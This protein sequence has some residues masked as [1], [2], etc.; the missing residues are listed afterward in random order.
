MKRAVA[1]LLALV[2]AAAL[3]GALAPAAD[4]ELTTSVYRTDGVDGHWDGATTNAIPAHVWD[5]QVI[6]NTVYVGGQFTE[7]V[8]AHD[9]W[10]RP[11]QPFLAAF[12][13]TSGR[14]IDWWRPQLDAPV[15]A[16]D[17]SADGSLLVAGEFDHVNGE[18]HSNLVAL[19]PRSGAIDHR[20]N[21]QVLRPGTTEQSVIRDLYRHDGQLYVVGN[22]TRIEGGPATT[23]IQVTK[24]ARVDART[25]APD[26]TW[27]PVIAGRSAWAVTTSADGQRVHLGGEFSYVNGATDTAL[28]ATVNASNGA[29]TPGWN[30]GTNMPRASFWPEGGIVYDL[31][32]YGNNLFV[33]GAEHYWEVR[34]SLNGAQLRYNAIS[35]DSQRV[36]VFGDRVYISCHCYKRAPATQIIEVS[37]STGAKL[38]DLGG[39]LV[40][41]DGSWAFAKA[42]DGCLWSGGDFYAT[43]RLVGGNGSR[44][45][46]GRIARMCDSAG[47]FPHDVPSLTPPAPAPDP[48]L[49]IDRG[50]E[51]R[52]LADGT[53]PLGWTHAAFDDS[54]WATGRGELGYGDGDEA[55]VV[56]RN[57]RSVLFRRTFEADPATTPYL[58]LRLNVD[59]GAT[60]W[61]NGDPVV[62]ENVPIG[63]ITATT[64]A[65]S[66]VWGSAESDFSAYRLRG[67]TLVSGTNTIAVSVHQSDSSSNDLT[68]DLSL[69]RAS[70]A[71]DGVTPPPALTV[72][73][74]PPPAPAP[75]TTLVAAGSTWRYLDDGVGPAAGWTQPGFDDSAWRQGP[76]Q[77]G[78]GDGDEATRTRS[79][80]SA[81]TAWFRHSFTVTDPTAFTELVIGLVRD[82]GAAVY[83]NGVELTR[84]NLPTGTLTPQTLA[85]AYVN[86][87][88]ES[89][90]YDIPV[91]VGA[92]RAGTN[93]L[94]VEVHQASGSIDLS[95]DLRLVAR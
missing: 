72:P 66:G 84:S 73:Q 45:W 70:D 17:V 26:A 54:G 79:S 77:L 56:P 1:A 30:N 13:A 83:L 51:W 14:W 62:A 65:A 47:P 80:G 44:N 12:D 69:S 19:D 48:D 61:I 81:T 71:P 78:Y 58:D 5:E 85:L 41:G 60:V 76:A 63:E 74:A 24:A 33:T 39:S 29:L 2:C 34:S 18:A 49:L 23:R 7:V 6:G 15:W 67:D 31:A 95:F 90:F 3:A 21:A 42:P 25:G 35:N 9:A 82:D 93:V 37:G 89:R 86:N 16:L 92:L 28:L 55:T 27:A 36:E 8:E 4:A 32:V 75:E 88:D 68:F 53:H 52:Y 22:F 46:V 57:G 40:S 11:D 91:G 10:L 94:A 38:R 64:W 50:A 87:A 20:F 59:D 43:T